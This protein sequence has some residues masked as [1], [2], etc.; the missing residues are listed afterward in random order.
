MHNIVN[1][2]LKNVNKFMK[3]IINARSRSE[4]TPMFS[5]MYAGCM[6]HNQPGV[7]FPHPERA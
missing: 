6:R 1:K 5:F 2:I 3:F 7:P 4:S